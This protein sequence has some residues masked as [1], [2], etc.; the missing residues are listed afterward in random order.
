[1]QQIVNFLIRNRNVLLYVL[2][3][4][5]GLVFTIQNHSY[6]RNT[7]IH[8]SGMLTGAMLK[9]RTNI[10]SYFGLKHENQLLR[11]ENARLRM[12]LLQSQ[13]SLLGDVITQLDGKTLP[14][15]V[16]PARVVKND[17]ALIDNYLTID[18]GTNQGIKEDM[19]VI[20]THGILG[21]VDHAG[22]SYSRVISI[23]NSNISLNAQIKGTAIIGS[24]VWNGN[25]PYTMSLVDVPRL[26][27]VVKG[28]TIV[29]G[30]QSLTYPPDIVIGVIQEAQ[31]VDNGSRYSIKVRL[32]NDMTN[33]G[34][35][36]VI[37]N[38]DLTAIQSL[39]TIDSD[40]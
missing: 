19:G 10:S 40:E 33:V 11:D 23:L 5:I 31:L 9:S 36:Y 24:L 18:I 38:R 20:S 7:V 8:S 35:A 39:D 17:Y 26:A 13:D 30:Q 4:I 34:T 37:Y 16:Y 15:K 1:M 29:T 25:D 12:Q 32:I 2:L 21:V 28:D 22:S 27:K 3:V 6:H 14:F